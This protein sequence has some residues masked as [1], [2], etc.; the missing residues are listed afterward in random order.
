MLD[1]KEERKTQVHFLSLEDLLPEDHLV[2]KLEKAIDLDFI[3]EEV[4]K[5]YSDKG[6]TSKR[7]SQRPRTTRKKELTPLEEKEEHKETKVS[8]TDP[9]SG[10]FHKGEHKKVFAY[11][12]NVA[13]DKNNYILDFELN[14]GNKH[15]STEFPNLYRKLKKNYKNI[16][17]VVVDAGYKTPAIAKE[18]LD[19][20]KILVTPYKRPMTKEGFSR[21]M[22]M[23]M[24]NITTVIYVQTMKF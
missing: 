15:D 6:R 21:N 13:C 16:K 4:K 14:A 10:V 11:V 8:T 12:T 9:E 18:V 3:Y 23:L 19:D 7:N 22:S 20:G 24:M 2:R 17:N 5:L 1:K